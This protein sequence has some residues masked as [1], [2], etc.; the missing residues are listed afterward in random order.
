MNQQNAYQTTQS[1]IQ[2]KIHENILGSER[3][4]RW[5]VSICCSAPPHLRLAVQRYVEALA[6]ATRTRV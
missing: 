4:Q 3:G 2:S 5:V 6:L 1:S